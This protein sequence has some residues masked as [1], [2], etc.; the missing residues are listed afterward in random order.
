M[1][2]QYQNRDSSKS[3]SHRCGALG[4]PL[5]ANLKKV[6]GCWGYGKVAVEKNLL[7]YR[8]FCV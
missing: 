7:Y 5:C 4:D 6:C 2:Q 8:S 3:M 1:K